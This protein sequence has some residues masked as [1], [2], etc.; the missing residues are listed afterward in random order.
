M[1]RNEHT[2]ELYTL[3]KTFIK[4]VGDEWKA[5]S[6]D[7]HLPLSHF[8]MMMFLHSNGQQKVAALAECLQVTPGA[9]T[10]IAD[11]LL[12][13]GL[14]ERERDEVDRRVV[15]LRLTE[16]GRAVVRSLRSIE[17][18]LYDDIINQLDPHDIEYMTRI[19]NTMIQF[20][21]THHQRQG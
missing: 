16:D 14:I 12:Q 7:Y 15:H 8:R 5:R 10:G 19:F 21:D 13:R 3:F 11:K 18:Q 2:A 9:V 1:K 6:Q 4:K 20:I 17:Q